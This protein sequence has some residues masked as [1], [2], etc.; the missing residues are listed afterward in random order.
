V[1]AVGEPD[2][3]VVDALVGRPKL[4]ALLERHVPA[5]TVPLGAHDDAG[6]PHDVVLRPRRWR[7]LA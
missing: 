1:P 5:V 7:K 3:R 2:V 4:L 6:W